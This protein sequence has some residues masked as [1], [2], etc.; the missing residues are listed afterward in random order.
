MKRV[1]ITIIKTEFNTNI[2]LYM[3]QYFPTYVQPSP[4][5][6]HIFCKKYGQRDNKTLINYT[7]FES[8]YFNGDF[9]KVY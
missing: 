3:V 1:H 9:F 4:F 6:I 7:E 2:L 5:T 8:R